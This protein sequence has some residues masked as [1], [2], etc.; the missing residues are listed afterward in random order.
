MKSLADFEQHKQWPLSK[1]AFIT[2]NRLTRHCAGMWVGCEDGL[3][4]ENDPKALLFELR[5]NCGSS[6]AIE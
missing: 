2:R 4:I 1:D 6:T 3:V 5:F